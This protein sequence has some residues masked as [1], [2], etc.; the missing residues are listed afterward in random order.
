M[1]HLEIS[2]KQ[3]FHFIFAKSRGKKKSPLTPLQH[4]PLTLAFFMPGEKKPTILDPPLAKKIKNKDGVV[5]GSPDVWEVDLKQ[6][7]SDIVSVTR[8][9]FNNGL[10]LLWGINT[11]LQT[12]KQELSLIRDVLTDAERRS[13]TEKAVHRW[14]TDVREVT[15]DMED[16]VDEMNTEHLRLEI[17]SKNHPSDE[18]VKNIIFSRVWNKVNEVKFNTL[19]KAR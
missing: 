12:L 8:P 17:K 14:R 11:E 19:I 9:I 5:Q 16:I 15:Y 1:P 13:T 10:G 2:Y 3:T 6:L 18:Q 4:L 7:F